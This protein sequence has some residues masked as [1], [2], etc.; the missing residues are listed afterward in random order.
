MMVLFDG[1][2][3]SCFQLCDKWN[4]HVCWILTFFGLFKIKVFFRAFILNKRFDCV[5]PGLLGQCAKEL[6]RP[7]VAIFNDCL[8][9]STWSVVWKTSSVMPIHKKNV[10]TE[11]KN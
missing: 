8:R 5:S 1:V 7:L 11:A 4:I 3:R 6:A 10:N 9:S 2:C